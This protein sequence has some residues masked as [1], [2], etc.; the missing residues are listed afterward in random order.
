M[1]VRN[2]SALKLAGA[3]ALGAVALATG[4]A[5]IAQEKKVLSKEEKEGIIFERQQIM[6]SLEGKAEI[7]GNIAAG[8]D[9][10]PRKAGEPRKSKDELAKESMERMLTTS[11]EIAA[12]A[13]E[14]RT[15]FEPHV[16][17]GRS[18]PEIWTTGADDYKKRMDNWVKAADEMVKVAEGG[19]KIGVISVM[20]EALPC[21]QC[22]DVYRTPPKPKT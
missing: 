2:L 10:V 13:K 21:K 14:A 19:N 4:Q 6:E 15:S 3:V 7:L 9:A 18:K 1:T 16:P 5:T 17:G 22:H 11:R 8:L 20:G 12:L